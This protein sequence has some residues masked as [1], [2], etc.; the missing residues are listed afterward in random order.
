MA[1]QVIIVEDKAEDLR[2]VSNYLADSKVCEPEDVRSV[3]TYDEARELIEDRASE[4]DLILLDLN[5]PRNDQDRQPEKGHGRRLLEHVHNLNKRSQANMNVIIVSAEELDEG[6]DNEML[7]QLYAGTLVGSVR[8]DALSV[9]LKANLKRLR[10]DPLRNRI[11]KLG[12]QTLDEYDVVM[13]TERAPGD[14]LEKARSLAIKLARNEMDCFEGRIGASERYADN[15]H[16]LAED[17][18]RRFGASPDTR[19]PEIKADLIRTDGGWGSFLWRGW[20]VQHLYALNNYRRHFVHEEEQPYAGIASSPN[21]WQPPAD[22]LDSL[23]HG[24]LLVQV[25]ELIVREL[26]EWYIPWHEQVY[27]PWVNS[28]SGKESENDS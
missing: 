8:K 1:L 10:R 24:R 25:V 14:R 26:L 21:A 16:G 28:L 7:K 12:I 17:L 18:K 5:I 19:R 20:H 27:M 9:M 2:E 15:L 6:W 3:A 11:A 4:T 22:V 13:N 23:S